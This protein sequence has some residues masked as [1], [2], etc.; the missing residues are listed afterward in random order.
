VTSLN[1][2]RRCKELRMPLADIKKLVAVQSAHCA[3]IEALIVEQLAQIHIAQY[4]LQQ[5]EK[6]LQALANCC[7]RKHD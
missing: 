2:I 3:Q 4:E 1:F 5:L 7:D 6:H